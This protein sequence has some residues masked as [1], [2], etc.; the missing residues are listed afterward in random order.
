M[1]KWILALVY[2]SFILNT[3]MIPV[4]HATQIDAPSSENLT[5]NAQEYPNSIDFQK[6]KEQQHRPVIAL[7]LGSG[8]ARGYAHIG[9][10]DV[11][12]KNGIRPD[13]IVGTSA[14]SIV[15]ALYAS[16]KTPEQMKD[17]ALNLKVQDVREFKIRKK[18][19]LDGTKVQDFVNKQVNNLPLEKMKIPLFVV[20]TQLNNGKKV[21]FNYGNTGQAVSASVAIPS[22]FIPTKI[23]GQEYVDGG[24][25]SPVPVEVA[26]QL[27]ADIVIAVDILAQPKYTETENMWGLFN[28]NINIMQQHLSQTELKEADVVIQPDLREKAHIF[29]VK[30]RSNTM[31]A[32][33]SATQAKIAN[34]KD[35]IQE[36]S[37]EYNI[38]DFTNGF[39]KLQT[40]N[41][42]LQ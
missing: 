27:G 30:E 21:V 25:V 9:A 12:E 38:Q 35:I 24:L 34:I 6:I 4:A 32:G 31:D 39:A 23:A 36:K 19:F 16:G 33:E 41:M 29:D 14:G 28:Q 17:I 20:A 3:A 22:M 2:S 13:F 37:T 15:G 1:K 10:I 42:S 40:P 5:E 8:G 7:V 26:R 11:L 18:G